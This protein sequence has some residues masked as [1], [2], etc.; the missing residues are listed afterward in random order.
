MPR[1]DGSKTLKEML[2]D[3]GETPVV[4][5]SDQPVRFSEA[6]MWIQATVVARVPGGD[7][8]DAEYEIKLPDG[9]T[10]TLS[11]DRLQATDGPRDPDKP[12]PPAEDCTHC[13]GRTGPHGQHKF[14]CAVGGANRVAIN[15]K[16]TED[17]KLRVV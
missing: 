5:T 17:G 13:P 1:P 3:L 7:D 16:I 2:A 12:W 8:W 6:A 10:I 15:A 11:G 14:G 9:A 4:F